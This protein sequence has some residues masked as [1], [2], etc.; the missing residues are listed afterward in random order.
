MTLIL[1]LAV[2]VQAGQGGGHRWN[3]LTIFEVVRTWSFPARGRATTHAQPL[4]TS[5]L[6]AAA[7][8]A[9]NEAIEPKL[10]SIARR[11]CGEASCS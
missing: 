8:A 7:K 4:P 6:A 9:R 10:R 1:E 5:W 3:L 11:S 2:T